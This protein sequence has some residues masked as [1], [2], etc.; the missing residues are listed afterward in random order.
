MKIIVANVQ[1]Q[2][3]K[4]NE[5][6]SLLHITNITTYSYAPAL[7]LHYNKNPGSIYCKHIIIEQLYSHNVVDDDV[8]CDDVMGDDVIGDDVVVGCGVVAGGGGPRIQN[9]YS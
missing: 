1:V 6:A 8:G 3:T 4:R 7:E 9:G 2:L 5:C